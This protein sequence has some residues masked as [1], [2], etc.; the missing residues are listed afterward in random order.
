MNIQRSASYE[1]RKAKE[2]RK[3]EENVVA[4]EDEFVEEL[5]GTQA[6]QALT[7]EGG[8]E[9]KATPKSEGKRKS[10]SAKT[11]GAGRRKRKPKVTLESDEEEVAEQNQEATVAEQKQE[12]PP[13]EKRKGER[14]TD[15]PKES[16][17]SS[18]SSSSSTAAAT[19]PS[20]EPQQPSEEPG[21][22]IP[23]L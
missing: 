11:E 4:D 18:S 8:D 12:L 13:Q 16:V 14:R 21:S 6:L 15:L 20:E 10:G 23:T 17:S 2:K 3:D 7:E 9:E 5:F 1:D 19:Q 22:A